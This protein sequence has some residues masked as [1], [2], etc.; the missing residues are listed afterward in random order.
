MLESFD[1]NLCFVLVVAFVAKM[2]ELWRAEPKGDLR[3]SLRNCTFAEWEGN[4]S[5]G[6][7][8][9]FFAVLVLYDMYIPILFNQCGAVNCIVFARLFDQLI[10]SILVVGDAF[11]FQWNELKS[12]ANCK[13]IFVLFIYLFFC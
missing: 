8:G 10:G 6:P 13:D 5:S 11:V 7:K 12:F 9:A 1:K 4:D 3:P 2:W